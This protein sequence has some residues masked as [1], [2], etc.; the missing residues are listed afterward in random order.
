MKRICCLMVLVA[1][2]AWGAPAQAATITFGGGGTAGFNVNGQFA[3]VKHD[4]RERARTDRFAL[5]D[6]LERMGLA[7]RFDR[8]RIWSR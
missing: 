5:V 1:G 7:D 8:H 2:L 3:S 4:F 6:Q